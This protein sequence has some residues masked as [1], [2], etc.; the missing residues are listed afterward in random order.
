MTQFFID[1]N[2]YHREKQ[3][4]AQRYESEYHACLRSA[5]KDFGLRKSCVLKFHGASIAICVAYLWYAKASSAR[6]KRTSTK[7]KLIS[8]RR[9]SISKEETC[10]KGRDKINTWVV[11]HVNK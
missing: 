4:D 10:S 5:R 9:K 11:E 6:L 3:E 1:D 2:F 8:I 7:H